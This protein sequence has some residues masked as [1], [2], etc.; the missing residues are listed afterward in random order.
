MI[1]WLNREN[2]FSFGLKRLV[3]RTLPL[4]LQLEIRKR[5]LLRVLRNSTNLEDDAEGVK[6]LV[7]P[8]D[9]VIDV[10]ANVGAYTVLLSKLVGPTGRVFAFEPVP[11]NYAVLAYAIKHLSLANVIPFALGLSNSEGSAVMEIPSFKING[12]SL[13]D[14]RIVDCATPGLRS[15]SVPI[16]TLDSIGI[17]RCTF[18]K[19]DVEGHEVQVLC[20]ARETIRRCRPAIL[21]ETFE[22]PASADSVSGHC[23]RILTDEAY[24]PMIFKVGKFHRWDGCAHPQNLFFLR[25]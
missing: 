20:G 5:T 7:S 24:T 11:E 19:I 3:K 8:G 2:R 16:K 18:L 21:M 17:E 9:A 14:S 4:R 12:E 22:P 23:V 13:Y 1:P 15:V 6:L 25:L 10:G